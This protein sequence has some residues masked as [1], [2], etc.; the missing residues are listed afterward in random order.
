MVQEF[1][2]QTND[3]KRVVNLVLM[4]EE[5]NQDQVVSTKLNAVNVPKLQTTM[6]ANRLNPSMKF[7]SGTLRFGGNSLA[8]NNSAGFNGRMSAVVNMTQRLDRLS[9]RAPGNFST[10]LSN[11]VQGG[12][13]GL[14]K[15]IEGREKLLDNLQQTGKY[16]VEKFYQLRSD[17]DYFE[18]LSY[19]DSKLSWTGEV[20]PKSLTQLNPNLNKTAMQLNRSIL[21]YCGDTSFPY[22][23]SAA[24]NLIETTLQTP[25]LANEVYL[26]IIKQLTANSRPTSEDRGW[27]LLILATQQFAPSKELE[28][29]VFNFLITLKETPLLVGNYARLCIVQLDRTLELGN[30]DSVPDVDLI[31]SYSTRPALLL[32]ISTNQ[33]SFSSED[34]PLATIDI[35][36]YP[37]TDVDTVVTTACQIAGYS[38]SEVE[39]YGLFVTGRKVQVRSA[40]AERL[41]RFYEVWDRSK[42]KHVEYFAAMYA[43]KEEE[44]FQQLVEKYGPEPEEKRMSKLRLSKSKSKIDRE[45]VTDENLLHPIS[46]WIYPGDVFFNYTLKGKEPS[47]SLQRK[48]ILGTERPGVDLVEQL[49]K[50]VS[51]GELAIPQYDD[52]TSL[53]ALALSMK[54]GD[55]ISNTT[56]I[57]ALGLDYIL[58]QIWLREQAPKL[59]ANDVF[60]NSEKY[61]D[62]RPRDL[63]KKFVDICQKSAGYGVWFY[64]V[65]EINT[66][67]EIDGTEIRELDYIGIS[68]QGI[69]LFDV[70]RTEILET[71]SYDLIQEYGA[72]NGKIW[73]KLKRNNNYSSQEVS[74]I[75]EVP[76]EVYSIVYSYLEIKSKLKEGRIRAP[77]TTFDRESVKRTKAYQ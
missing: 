69:N 13:P 75:T 6:N 45:D 54:N 62:L 74:F 39:L 53:A 38:S 73:F 11:R 52:I 24:Q 20:I 17:A 66:F 42:L 59:T 57:L 47:F 22:P 12:N 9:G 44:L 41:E 67:N 4:N 8:L 27:I 55:P 40:L 65:E 21:Q 63:Y 18:G 14:M 7:L 36:V 50:Q 46:W 37:D 58:P 70:T 5:R 1:D 26:Q 23:S 3:A 56:E 15:L 51:S 64:P 19:E 48:I 35:P 68:A 10:R 25:I 32:T 76:W 31:T 33:V 30:S 29:Y 72:E 2:L 71:Y 28:P 49:R 16:A 43:R 34:S 61:Q 77:R 60:A